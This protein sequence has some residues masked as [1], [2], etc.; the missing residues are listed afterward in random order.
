MPPVSSPSAGQW[1]GGTASSLAIAT[2]TIARQFERCLSRNR[3]S[4][5]Q[6]RAERFLAAQRTDR[7][8][9]R[10]PPPRKSEPVRERPRHARNIGDLAGLEIAYAAWKLS[11]NG[12]QAG[13]HHYLTGDQRFF[14]AYACSYRGIV[15]DEP[16][17]AMLE[18]DSHAPTGRV[19]GVVRNMD[20]WY[21]A[22]N[23]PGDWLYLPPEERVRLW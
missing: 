15:R 19:N 11:S 21:S 9:T 8:A 4:G 18:G 14:L 20:A 10:P 12:K 22:F 13:G 23:K 16:A 5:Q 6:S 7:P 1:N 17:R 2:P 3:C